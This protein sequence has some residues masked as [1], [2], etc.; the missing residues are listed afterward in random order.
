MSS[1]STEIVKGTLLIEGKTK[2]VFAVQGDD[3]VVAIELKDD[4]TAGNGKLHDVIPG[5]GALAAATICNVFELLKQCG[6]PV[7]FLRRLTANSF[8]AQKTKMLPFEVIC[9]RE[10]HGSARKKYPFLPTGHRFEHVVVEFCLKTS[11]KK[12]NWHDLLCDDPIMRVTETSVELYDPDLPFFGS[13][14]FLVLDKSEV[15]GLEYI[16]VMAELAVKAFLVTEKAWAI[17]GYV[18]LD[19]K[20]EFGLV[21]N[22]TENRWDLLLSDDIEPSSWRLRAPDGRYFDKE[23]YRMG[24]DIA[25]MMVIYEE[26]AKLTEAFRVPSQEIVLWTGS[27]NDKVTAFDEQISADPQIF[28]SACKVTVTKL[29][30]SAHKES[31]RALVLASKINTSRPSGR[32]IIAYVGMSNAAGPVLAANSMDPVIAVPQSFD[33]FSDDVWSSLRMPSDVPLSVILNPRNALMQALQILAMSNPYLYMILRSRQEIRM[34]NSAVLNLGW[35]P[36]PKP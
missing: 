32:V 27:P 34:V 20:V 18:E 7:A 10:V 25:G 8:M 4:I 11:G 33:K 3:A 22:S 29:C 16:P 12:Y 21:W 30:A 23:F 1:E 35:Q 5:K 2:K 31:G 28:G 9:R 14:P 13:E 17:L 6:L 19:H 26:T 36:A 15:E 24:G